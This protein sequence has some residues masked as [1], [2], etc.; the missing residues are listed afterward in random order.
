[1]L[2]QFLNFAEV[3]TKNFDPDRVRTPVLSMST[4]ALMGI[5]QVLITPVFAGLRSGRLGHR[6]TPRWFCDPAIRDA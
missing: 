6:S 2:S 5:V 3:R 4:R 1:M